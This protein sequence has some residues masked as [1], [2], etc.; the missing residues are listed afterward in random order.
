MN[1]NQFQFPDPP[2]RGPKP[3]PRAP[4]TP[5]EHGLHRSELVLFLLLVGAVGLAFASQAQTV[6][7]FIRHLP[8]FAA[9]VADLLRA[10]V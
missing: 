5:R 1:R 7:R 8:E 9:M 4:L 2:E 10:V 3:P 6:N